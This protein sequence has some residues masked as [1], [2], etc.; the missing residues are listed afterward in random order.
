MASNRSSFSWLKGFGY[1]SVAFLCFLMTT[2]R[3]FGQVDEG[4]ITGTVEDT[5]GAV[6][7]NA[8]VTLLNTDMGLTLQTKTNSGG[9]YTFSPVRIGHYTLTFTAPGFAKTTQSNV[10]V[11]VAQALQ[12]NAKLKPGSASETVEVTAAPPLMQ[13]E[14]ASVGQTIDSRSVNDLP[15]NGRNFTFLAQLGAG[16]QTPQADTRGNA[17]SGAFSANGL[18]P[19]QNNY[20]LDGIDNNSDTVDFLNGTN[21]VVLPPLDAVQ[22]FKVQTADFSAQLGRSAGAVLNAT[23]KSGTNNIHGAMWE[24]FRNRVLDASDWF[25]NYNHIPK[26]ALQQNQFGVSMGG[27]FIKN[28]LFFFGDYEGLRRVLGSPQTGSV[29][30]TLEA[31]SGFTNMSD[32]I[33]AQPNAAPLKDDLGRTIPQGTVLD[34]ATTRLVTAGVL[35]P[36]SGRVATAT[37]Y[38]RDAF[39][40]TCGANPPGGVYSLSSCPDLN[41]IP[42]GRLNT[43]AIELLKLYPRPTNSN[44]ANL[45]SNYASNP[46]LFEHRNA[47]DIRLDYNPSAKN[48]VFFRVSYVDD[49]QYIPGIFGGIADGGAFQQGIQTA[50]SYQYAGAWTHV[51]NPSTINVARVGLNHLH[52]TRFGPE[53]NNLGIPAQYGIQGIPQVPENGGL[54]SYGISGLSTLGSNAFLPSDEISQTLQLTDDFT[55]VWGQHSFKMGIES[56]HIK[57]DTLQ[58]AFSRG[59]FDY[60]GQYA[61]VPNSTAGN[62]GRAQFLLSPIAATVPNGVNYSGGADSINAS[63]INT[64]YDYKTYTAL[65]FE[66]DWKVNPNLTLNLGLRWD[67]FGPIQETNGGQANFVPSALNNGTPTYLLPAT[68]KDSRVLSS[69]ADNPSLNGNGFVDLL[70]KDGILLEE[71]NKY[72]RGLVRNQKTNFAPRVGAAYQINPKL[73]VR[74]GFGIF[75]NSFENQGYSPNIGENYPFVYNFSYGPQVPAGSPDGLQNV[76]PIGYNTPWTGCQTASPG[77]TYTLESGLSCVAFTPAD[78]NAQGLGLEGVQFDWTTPRTLSTNLTV[79][80]SLTRDMTVQAA[81]VFTHTS[82]L[83]VGLSTNNV[84]Q[85]LTANAS[86]T[87]AVPWPDFSHGMSYQ[88]TIGSSDYNGLQTKLEQQYANGLSFLLTYTYSKTLGDAGDLLNGGSTGGFRAPSVPGLGPSFDRARANFDIRQVVHFSGGYELPIGQG[89]RF[90]HDAGPV[91][92]HVIGGWSVNWIT[93]LQGGQPLNFGC[94]FTTAAGLGCNDLLTGDPKLGLHKDPSGALNWIG[95]ASAFNQPCQLGVNPPTPTGCIPLTGPAALG[96]TPG[97]ISGPGFHR[98]D[99]SAFKAIKINDRW[100]AQF[101]AEFFNILNHPNFNAPNFGGNGVVGV[102]GSGNYTSSTFGEIGSTRD[103]PYDPRQIQFALKLYY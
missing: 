99:F 65:Y 19:A 52:T 50:K 102:S 54:P 101:R 53:G 10:T 61:D 34:P 43:N 82:N 36:V 84:S 97:Q 78:V 45:F 6:V 75:F 96:Q 2:Q 64:T 42:A 12:V 59:N 1:I 68:G 73:V 93:V 22:E 15:L 13:T 76:S 31:S 40:T 51:F 56:Q 85:I 72:G 70:A 79:Q 41:Q 17:A 62:L 77:G 74:G 55:K 46:N 38:V 8:Q 67:Y 32:L 71:T 87:N 3:V 5:T 29:P 91:T 80:Y 16:T 58:P 27:P 26:G 94:P 33:A 63:N 39:S 35:D 30:S 60:N 24:F 25:E 9:A 81:Y 88:T 100:T 21:F 4:S 92:N 103:S 28:K 90:F 98:L 49:P 44:V 37:G 20:L 69:T 47:F 7:P 11:N 23:I 57:F 66:D 86:T 89:K 95:N 14:D 48:Q 83:Q 18:R